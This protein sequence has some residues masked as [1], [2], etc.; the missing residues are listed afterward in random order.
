[1]DLCSCTYGCKRSKKGIIWF[2]RIII[3]Y[4]DVNCSGWSHAH[5]RHLV[6]K[7]QNLVQYKSRRT[8]IISEKALVKHN[9]MSVLLMLFGVHSIIVLVILKMHSTDSVT[10]RICLNGFYCSVMLQPIYE[11]GKIGCNYLHHYRCRPR[12]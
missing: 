2:F 6:L 11:R 1:M 5:R 4:A 8:N 12:F 7:V 9:N 3:A 10:Q